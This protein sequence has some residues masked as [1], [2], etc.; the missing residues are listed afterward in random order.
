MIADDSAEFGGRQR[1]RWVVAAALDHRD[2]AVDGV[3]NRN[4][5][6]PLTEQDV[7]DLNAMIGD[8]PI[9]C[10][11]IRISRRT[12]IQSKITAHI[13]SGDVAKLCKDDFRG[14]DLIDHCKP[15]SIIGIIM[16]TSV[17]ESTAI[18]KNV[19]G[20]GLL[21][22]VHLYF[23][24]RQRAIGLGRQDHPGFKGAVLAGDYTAL[25]RERPSNLGG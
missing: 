23:K 7:H 13:E 5:V 1:C 3:F 17:I 25:N 4:L 9:K 8:S 24:N 16:D 12:E 2:N 6:I 18:V 21:S 15:I 14:L 20:V 10:A 11:H 19:Q 22:L